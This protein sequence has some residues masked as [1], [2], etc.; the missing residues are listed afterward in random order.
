M[1]FQQCFAATMSH[2]DISSKIKRF[3]SQ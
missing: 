3:S 2:V 1:T